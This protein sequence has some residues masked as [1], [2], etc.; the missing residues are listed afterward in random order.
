MQKNLLDARLFVLVLLLTSVSLAVSCGGGALGPAS[1][2]P[3]DQFAY[4]V[5][6]TYKK[7]CA[8]CHG[9]DFAGSSRGP[10]LLDES[11]KNGASLEELTESIAK[12][13]PEQRMPAWDGRLS[14]EQIRGIADLILEQRAAD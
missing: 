6:R 7:K 9:K 8:L 5:A 11:L 1:E 13:Y 2:S 10:S 14:A 3:E 4:E 12:G